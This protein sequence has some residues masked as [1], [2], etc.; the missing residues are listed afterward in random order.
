M[1]H[2]HNLLLDTL[3][4]TKHVDGA[5]LIKLQERSLCVT[6][7]GFSVMPSDVRTLVNGFAKNPLQARR[8]GLYFKEKVYKC[9]RADEHSLYAKNENTGVVVVKTRLYLLVATYT[10]GM[11]PSICVEAAE[12]L[13]NELHEGRDCYNYTAILVS[14]VPSTWRISKKKRKLS[15]QRTMNHNFLILK[16]NYRS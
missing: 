3:L 12:K 15:H 14:P 4:G 9:V 2:L 10:E 5:A 16:E 11:Y 7:P 13:G 1:S 6:S 8:E